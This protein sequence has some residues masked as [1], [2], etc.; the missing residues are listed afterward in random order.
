[1]GKESAGKTSMHSII[2]ANCP[3]FFNKIYLKFIKLAKD[4][5][6][7]GMTIERNDVKL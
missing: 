7:I 1:M 2:F 6:K 4:A 5:N 3:G